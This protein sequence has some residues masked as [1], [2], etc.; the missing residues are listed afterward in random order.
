MVRRDRT[1]PQAPLPLPA[2]PGGP[3]TR[4]GRVSVASRGSHGDPPV[5]S[6]APRR[7]HRGHRPRHMAAQVSIDLAVSE[8]LWRLLDPGALALDVGANIGFMTN[9]MAWR[10]GPCGRVLAFEPHPEVFRSLAENVER[11]SATRPSPLS[12]S[13]TRPSAN[14][15]A[16]PTSSA[17]NS[18]REIMGRLVSPAAS[19]LYGSQPRHSTRRSPEESRQWSRSMLRGRNSRSSMVP[20]APFGRGTFAASYTR[21]TRRRVRAWLS[22]SNL[23]VIKSSALVEIYRGLI[24]VAAGPGSAPAALRGAEFPSNTRSRLGSPPHAATRLASFSDPPVIMLRTPLERLSRG[25]EWPRPVAGPG[26]GGLPAYPP[27]GRALTP[28]P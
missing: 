9:L 3:E 27:A 22:S 16:T 15:S 7:R 10:S 12:S 28:A 2:Q 23:M 11:L 13:T 21:R 25:W 6:P 1:L 19:H 18:L 24:P 5:G 20:S 4:P 8:A 26:F 17:A 14:G